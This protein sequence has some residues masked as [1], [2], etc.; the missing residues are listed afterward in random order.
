WWLRLYSSLLQ[1]CIAAE[2][3][4]ACGED[5]FTRYRH[6]KSHLQRIGKKEFTIAA[7][8]LKRSSGVAA[9]DREAV[10]KIVLPCC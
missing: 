3:R 5:R 6:K 10:G 7:G 8:A 1:I 9:E 2:D 4:E